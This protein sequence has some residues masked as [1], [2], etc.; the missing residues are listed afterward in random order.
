MWLRIGLLIFTWA[1]TITGAN[2]QDFYYTANGSRIALQRSAQWMVVQVALQDIG[3][4]RQDS[5]PPGLFIKGEIDHNRG[6]F[7]LEQDQSNGLNT[8]L[9]NLQAKVQIVNT[10]PS[11]FRT[12]GSG[13]T[14]RYIL[15][16]EFIVK[17]RH[18]LSKTA[19]DSLNAIY[20]AYIVHANQ[21]GEYLLRVAQPSPFTALDLANVYY[22]QGFADWSEPNFVA[23]IHPQSINDPLFPKQWYLQ[24]TGQTGG[25]VGVDINAVPAWNIAPGSSAITVAVID[26]GIDNGAGL[27]EDFYVG[28]IVSGYTAGPAGEDGG[29]RPNQCGSGNGHGECVA[30]IIAANHNSIG[31]RGVANNVHLMPINIFPTDPTTCYLLNLS[32][33]NLATAIDWAW[34]HG[35]D[36]LNNSWRWG[37]C[38]DTSTAITSAINRAMTNGRGGKGCLVV[39]SAG[40]TYGGCVPFPANNAGVLTVGAVDHRNQPAIYTPHDPRVDVVAPSRPMLDVSAVSTPDTG[41][42]TTDRMLDKGYVATDN[43]VSFTGTSAAAPEVSG[44]GALMLSVNPNLL[45]RLDS[46]QVQ[47]IIKQTATDY[48]STNWDGY[49]RVNAYAAVREARGKPVRT[50][51]SDCATVSAPPIL[52]WDKLLVTVTSRVQVSTSTD[53]TNPLKDISGIT[54]TSYL[55]TGLANT[56]TY[57]WRVASVQSGGAIAWSDTGYFYTAPL[58]TPQLSVTTV[59]AWCGQMQCSHPKLTWTTSNWCGTTYKLYKYYGADCGD[60]FDPSISVLDLHWLGL[61]VYRYHDTAWHAALLRVLLCHG[62]SRAVFIDFKHSAISNRYHSRQSVLQQ[63][64]DIAYRG[65]SFQELSGSV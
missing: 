20:G 53:F 50:A 16:D 54:T 40:N 21:W 4:L 3:K 26:N 42:V 59:G 12:S 34:Q 1:C 61:I 62:S 6:I 57:Y 43:Y 65:C 14:S 25:P 31:V 52:Q 30:G 11:F 17:F 44:I 56:T 35:A 36:I 55:V 9:N 41:L 63:R 46:P 5:L 13:D 2:S 51:P 49:G 47:N 45:A 64:R 15:F 7:W 38:S 27:H 37:L 24:N 48:G 18:D 8:A 32:N 10:F 28:Q 39:F 19:I 23:D 29:G 33:D 22:T 60:P 58:L